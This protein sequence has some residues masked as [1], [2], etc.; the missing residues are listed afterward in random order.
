M[1]NLASQPPVDAAPQTPQAEQRGRLID[2]MKRT[3]GPSIMPLFDD[4][5]VVEI[6]LNPD[7]KLLVERHGIGITE[8]G[9]LS[10]TLARN[11]INL[12]A[13]SLETVAGPDRPILEGALPREFGGARFEGVLP[14]LVASPTFA[15]R[16]RAR[17]VFTLDQYVDQRI[18]TLEQADQIK[19]AVVDRKNILVSGGT[20]SGKTT[21]LNAV[22]HHIASIAG[23]DQRIVL[24]EDTAEL[25]CSAPNVVP[26]L[27]TDQ[28]D[29]TRL[30]KATMR[31]RPDRIVVGEVRDR[32]ALALLKSWNTG[33]PGGAATLHADSA[34][35]A[36][37]RLDML[38]QEGGVPSQ[39]D[40]IREAVHLVIQISRDPTHPSRRRVVEIRS[41]I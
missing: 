27:A 10:E 14:P 13:A 22:L 29:M 7:G 11:V 6:M 25:Q 17:T 18:M 39:R 23:L 31:L 12:V 16:L 2:Q 9:V 4:P 1:T 35:L 34:A 15:I 41:A 26:M 3:F 38:I 40:L 20:G 32:A 24:I 5:L 19:Q 36:L 28:I 33:H 8:A 30:L 37:L 21:L